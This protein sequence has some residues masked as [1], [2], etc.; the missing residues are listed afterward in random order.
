MFLILLGVFFF[1]L[2]LKVI[3]HGVLGFAG[4]ISIVI[5]SVMLVDLPKSV[6]SI[7]WKSILAV[8]VLSGI[9]FFGVLSYAIK[10]QLSKVKTGKEGIV[11]ET[12]IVKSDVLVGGE[13]KVLVHGELWN[14]RSE[15]PI[16]RGEKVVVAGVDGLVLIVKKKEGNR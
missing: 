12:G 14:A 11:G 15:E 10:A 1:I 5:G 7:S 2:E 3:S 4:I 16:G 13:G 8:A 9:F 6:L